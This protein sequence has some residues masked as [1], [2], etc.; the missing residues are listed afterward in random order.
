MML[1]G[2]YRQS[3]FCIIVNQLLHSALCDVKNYADFSIP[4]NDDRKS[5][6]IMN[7]NE[8]RSNHRHLNAHD[9]QL[10]LPNFN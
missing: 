6:Y 10:K 1:D 2:C 7:S 9:L 8:P 4:G 5:Y 3:T